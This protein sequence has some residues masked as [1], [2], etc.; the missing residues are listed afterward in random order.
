[1]YSPIQYH[2]TLPRV[3]VIFHPNST[4][5]IK[6][7]E[8]EVETA[9]FRK[10]RCRKGRVP[11]FLHSTS[12]QLRY[13]ARGEDASSPDPQPKLRH[14]LKSVDLACSFVLPRIIRISSIRSSASLNQE[15]DTPSLIAPLISPP[16]TPLNQ[17]ELKRSNVREDRDT[18]G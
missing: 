11:E 14:R 4:R 17:R 15:V 10:T 5:N 9:T 8:L 7:F 13:S 16:I 18:N 2:V 1:M 3:K 12:I 6:L